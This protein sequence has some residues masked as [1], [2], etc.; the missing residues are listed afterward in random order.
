MRSGSD[1]GCDDGA[2]W[3]EVALAAA[4]LRDERPCTTT[5]V[6]L[7]SPVEEGGGLEARCDACRIA[8]G[9]GTVRAMQA[10]GGG[11]AR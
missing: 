3:T 1:G 4:T 8:A 9:L 11:E 5:E 7:C 10:C 6:V 2:P